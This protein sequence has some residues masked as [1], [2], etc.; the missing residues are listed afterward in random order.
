MSPLADCT[1]VRREIEAPAS[2]AQAADAGSSIN[3][4]RWNC[5]GDLQRVLARQPTERS[6]DLPAPWHSEL[7]PKRIGVRLGR[8]RGDLEALSDLLVGA[9]GGDES[10]DLALPLGDPGRRDHESRVHG[11]H[12]IR[13]GARRPL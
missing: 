11:A 4:P 2:A 3:D 8:P 7:L 10:D 5:P 1:P 13:G 12:A 6:G 9:A